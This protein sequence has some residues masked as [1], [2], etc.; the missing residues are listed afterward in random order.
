[1]ASFSPVNFMFCLR[2]RMTAFMAAIGLLTTLLVAVP[3]LADDPH[4]AA[5]SEAY[6]EEL[7]GFVPG[8][9]RLEGRIRAPCCWNQTLDI[10]G[11]EVSNGLRREIRK[12][13]KAGES[14]EAIE[15]SIVKRYG[16][17]VLAVPP[18]SPLKSIATLLAI[19]MGVAGAL[20]IA[21]LMRWKKRADDAPASTNRQSPDKWDARLDDELSRLDES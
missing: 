1:V 6:T 11:S 17:K 21:L 12:R 14:P 9:N 16:E 10:H 8:A 5:T 15:A 20:A 18:G 3:V 13:L 7:Q 19:T 4:V 2:P